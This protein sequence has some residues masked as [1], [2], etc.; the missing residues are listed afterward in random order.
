MICASADNNIYL[1]QCAALENAIPEM[2][3][4]EELHDVDGSRYRAYIYDG[5]K[6]EINNNYYLDALYIKSEIQL[7]Q[8]FNKDFKT[9]TA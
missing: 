8:F 5:K 1:R 7:E 6:I 9:K 2:T 4:I 3:Q